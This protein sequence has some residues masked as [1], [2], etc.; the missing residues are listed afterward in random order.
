[1]RRMPLDSPRRYSE[2]DV[3]GPEFDRPPFEGVARK[4]F[5]CS[6]PRSGSYMLCRYLI[7]AGLGVPHEYFNP[8]VMRPIAERFG[9]GETVR[10]LKWAWRGRLARLVQPV[11]PEVAFLEAYGA[12][13][14][15]RRTAGGVFAAKIHY[16]QYERVLD[17][18]VGHELLQGG[19]FVNLVRDD[20]LGQAISFHVS[21][22]TGR[23]SV[24]DAVTTAPAREPNY[25]DR[26]AIAACIRGLADEDRGWRVFFA[27][28]GI[29]P[30]FVSYESFR[31]DPWR[32][33][34]AIARA[35]GIDPAALPHDYAEPDMPAEFPSDVPDRRKIREFFLQR[36][37]R[38]VPG[39]PP[40]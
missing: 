4:L 35:L 28:H 11:P 40:S 13:L 38:I 32:D 22:L 10:D 6:S 37:G 9:L 21:N 34:D 25:F 20:L 30:L 18:K 2:S 12:E 24:D 19:V 23:W 8:I 39:D 29:R 7:A 5:I 36:E 14:R 1:M 33:I 27:R 17:N 15:R 16:G 3:N 26:D 31:L